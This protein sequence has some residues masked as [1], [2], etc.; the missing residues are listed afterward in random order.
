MQDMAAS[1]RLWWAALATLALGNLGF[2]AYASVAFVRRRTTAPRAQA[3]RLPHLYLSAGVVLGTAFLFLVPRVAMRRLVLVD[4]WLSSALVGRCVES[5]V[6]LCFVVQW[7]LLLSEM[8]RAERSIFARHIAHSILPLAAVA[9]GFA[10]FAVATRNPMGLALE[11]AVWALM[12]SAT[13]V[14]LAELWRRTFKPLRSFLA[15]TVVLC[16]AFAAYA[17]L[18]DI[19]LHIAR[20]RADE[21]TP[22]VYLEFA[23]GLYDAATNY[24]VARDFGFFREQRGWPSFAANIVVWLSIA[25]MHAPLSHRAY[26]PSFLPTSGSKARLSEL[27]SNPRVLKN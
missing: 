22:H 16:M 26:R 24:V 1:V 18:I 21:A 3:A 6:E 10:W 20:F 7:S 9:Q 12:A 8:A 27:P 11:Q 4:T 15:L 23:Q 25:L 5:L 17:S 19:P 2:W 14:A 13:A